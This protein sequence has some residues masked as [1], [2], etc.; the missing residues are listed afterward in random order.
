[1]TNSSTVEGEHTIQDA[2][3]ATLAGVEEVRAGGCEV[4]KSSSSPDI[5]ET[6]N[7][8]LRPDEDEIQ[9]LR[10]KLEEA[11]C[12]NRVIEEEMNDLRAKVTS[13]D[14]TIFL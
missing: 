6:Y 3:E 9:L 5:V 2:D 8:N 12:R 4:K 14:F 10:L 11:Q 1:M 7:S 13:Y